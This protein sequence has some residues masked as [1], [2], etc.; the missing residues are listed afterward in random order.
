MTSPDV[1]WPQRT[2]RLVLR[3]VREEDV[4]GLLAFRNKPDV[5]KWLLKTEVDPDEFRE[6]WMKTLTHPRDYSSV[7]ELDGVV[8]GTA[9]LDV[10]DAMGQGQGEPM[11]GAEAEIGYILD[12]AFAGHGYATEIAA[13]LLR[14]CFEDL[15]VHRVTAGCYADNLA[16]RRVLEKVDMQLEQYGVRDSWHAELGWVDGCTYAILAEEWLKKGGAAPA[17]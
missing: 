11:E 9:S 3:Q 13:A 1:S 16:S 15:G 12:P 5:Y 8:I 7:V 14:I 2:E 10:S 6:A 4:D 17:R